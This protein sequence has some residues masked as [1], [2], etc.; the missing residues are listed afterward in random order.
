MKETYKGV[1][2]SVIRDAFKVKDQIKKTTRLNWMVL[3]TMAQFNNMKALS[4]WI[5]ENPSGEETL[6]NAMDAY[7]SGQLPDSPQ[8]E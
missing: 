8:N 5:A 3:G 6:L 1:P 2:K 4:Q 7:V